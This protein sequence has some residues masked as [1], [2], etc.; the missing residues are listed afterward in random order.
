MHVIQKENSIT[1]YILDFHTCGC[2]ESGGAVFL[3]IFLLAC[4]KVLLLKK[5][6]LGLPLALAM[7][8]FA[9]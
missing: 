5:I 7:D 2:L 1:F 6:T 8:G 3:L 4:S 9:Q